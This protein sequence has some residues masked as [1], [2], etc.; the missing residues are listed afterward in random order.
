MLVKR[1]EGLEDVATDVDEV[2]DAE[3]LEVLHARRSTGDDEELFLALQLLPCL[4]SEGCVLVVGR[5]ENDDIR[6]R[7]AGSLDTFGD[8]SKTVVVDDLISCAR[9]IRIARLPM[10][11]MK[12]TGCFLAASV[13]K[14]SCSNS[15]AARATGRV[16]SKESGVRSKDLSPLQ[17]HF[18]PDS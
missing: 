10:V 11:S 16:G 6:L 18:G 8:R 14:R 3:L 9:A 15:S 13:S 17:E 7:L 12:A 5:T 1:F 4:R 2:G